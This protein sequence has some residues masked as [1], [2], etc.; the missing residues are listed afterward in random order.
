MTWEDDILE[1]KQDAK[2]LQSYVLSLMERG[3]YQT[4][5]GLVLNLDAPWGSGKTFFLDRL[6]IQLS[7]DGYSVFTF[8]AWKHDYFDDPLL[9]LVAALTERRSSP[10][11]VQP[12][13]RTLRRR[14]SRVA[15]VAMVGAG[16]QFLRRAV[17]EA[18]EVIFEELGEAHEIGDEAVERIGDIGRT[19]TEAAIGRALEEASHVEVEQVLSAYAEGQVASETFHHALSAYVD[20]QEKRPVFL[21]IDELD[22]C[23]PSYSIAI[24]ERVKHFLNVPGLVTIFATD[25]VQLGNAVSGVYGTNYDGSEYL[26]RFFDRTFSFR[27]M[28]YESTISALLKRTDMGLSMFRSPIGRGDG[29][30]ISTL[31]KECAILSSAFGLTMR[32]I[33]QVIANLDYSTTFVESGETFNSTLLLYMLMLRH[34]GRSGDLERAGRLVGG[35]PDD[36]SSHGRLKEQVL[37]GF[38]DTEEGMRQTSYSLGDFLDT[39]LNLGRARLGQ[40]REESIRTPSY[41][42]LDDYVMPSSWRG[43]YVIDA[44]DEYQIVRM[45]IR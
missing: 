2:A 25:V 28:E 45:G 44:K 23:R 33:E 18:A 8:N 26:R 32:D 43:D 42:W 1:R 4:E 39:Y 24:L 31:A 16:K 34:T 35:L 3:K 21:L 41:Q 7:Q 37:T 6:K 10:A 38:Y 36:L 40:V 30:G 11:E 27:R 29:V 15:R 19:T 9:P 20:K 12:E 14:A 22:R 5:T 17:G 13:A